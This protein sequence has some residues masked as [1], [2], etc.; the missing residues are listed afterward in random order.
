MEKKIVKEV[1]SECG[2]KLPLKREMWLLCDSCYKDRET[3]E[4][5]T[6]TATGSIR[7][8][9]QLEKLFGCMQGLGNMGSS[10]YIEIFYDGDGSACMKF[11]RIDKEN[12]L[13][14]SEADRLEMESDG[15]EKLEFSFE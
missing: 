6:Y 9:N 7:S 4:T 5:R 12:D 11:K 14:D 13:I 2:A 1:C 8:L 10:D 15:S 3:D